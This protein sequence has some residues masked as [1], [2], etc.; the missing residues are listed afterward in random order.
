MT[1]G[2]IFKIFANKIIEYKIADK[3]IDKY[4]LTAVIQLFIEFPNNWPSFDKINNKK[5]HTNSCITKEKKCANRVYV[6]I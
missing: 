2:K 3:Y 5:K 1:P 6:I 4:L